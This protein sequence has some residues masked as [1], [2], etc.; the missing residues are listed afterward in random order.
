MENQRTENE[1]VP[2]HI[3][4][5]EKGGERGRENEEVGRERVGEEKTKLTVEGEG[6]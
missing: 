2:K 5:R 3:Y 6:V 1:E 4:E